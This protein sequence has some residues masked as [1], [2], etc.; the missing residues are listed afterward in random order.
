MRIAC[1]YLREKK[2]KITQL[3]WLD[4]LEAEGLGAEDF[5]TYDPPYAGTDVRCY[6]CDSLSHLEL[7]SYLKSAKHRWLLNE[8]PEPLYIS[9][10]GSPLLKE[11]MQLRINRFRNT[12]RRIKCQC[13]WSS[14]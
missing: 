14:R 7:V 4:C 9:A 3:D 13:L 8:S 1:E 12:P 11:R 6:S 2:V 10:F 5:V